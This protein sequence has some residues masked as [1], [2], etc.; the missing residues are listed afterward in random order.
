MSFIRSISGIRAT[1]GEGLNPAVLSEYLIAFSNITADGPIVIGRDG[2]ESGS[3]IEKLVISILESQS[4]D[5]INL[6]ISPTPTIQLITEHSKAAGGISI[7]AS[8]N[9]QQWNGLK[10]LN[11]NGIFLNQEDNNNV[12]ALVDNKKYILNSQYKKIKYE[13]IDGREKHLESLLNLP[14]VNEEIINKIRDKK[15]KVVVDAVNASGSDYLP[16]LLEYLGC[17]VINLYTDK[18]GIFPHT[19]EPLPENLNDLRARVKETDSDLGIAVD[20]DADRL[21]L[22]NNKGE[23]ISEEK[24]LVFCGI[25][26][27]KKLDYFKNYSKTIVTNLSTSNMLS[28]I[29]KKYGVDIF[30]AP[31]GEINVVNKMKEIRSF[32]GGE[33][34]GGIIL[35]ESHYGRDSLVGT[36]LILCLLTETGKSISELDGEIPRL[37]MKKSKFQFNG[38]FED[39]SNKM[40]KEF[41]NY[42]FNEEDGI[43]IDLSE[44]QWIHIR[45]SNTEPILRVIC[46][47][48]SDKENIKL[49]NRVT[50]I[51]NN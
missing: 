37:F 30:R 27:L 41:K 45:K 7:T 47:S 15:F 22:V 14:F 20:P 31:V 33:G 6:G 35:P 48:I 40:K 17:E 3:W 44:T 4:R 36:F 26:I 16:F 24:S 32:Y 42:K 29:A 12:W 13:E 43:R 46:E 34:S 1:L 8:H 11:Q 51:I 28:I 38:S 50:E 19:P 23:S 9:P 25:S 49:S 18:S 39:I 21:V 5:I 10:F 2:R